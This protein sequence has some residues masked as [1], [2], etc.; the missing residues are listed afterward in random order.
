MMVDFSRI[1]PAA[2]CLSSIAFTVCWV[3]SALL[4]DE[5]TLGEYSLSS[6]GACGVDSAEMF[7]NFGCLITGFLVIFPGLYLIDEKNMMFRIS[8]YAA[9][10]CSLACAAIG[11]ITENYGGMHNLTASVYAV[12]AATFI[13][14][15]GAGDYAEGKKVLTAVA[16]ILLIISGILSLATSFEVFEPVAVSCILLWTFIQSAMLL[17]RNEKERVSGTG[18]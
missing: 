10:I 2:G 6:L 18:H 7:F 16:A 13:A 17:I 3:I 8:G 14:S 5:W 1:G 11:V 9:L 4:W 12:F 15:S